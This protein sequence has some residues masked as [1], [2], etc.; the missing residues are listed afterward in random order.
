MER[1]IA[2]VDGS[3]ESRR[4][5]GT[6]AKLA[7]ALGS[8]LTLTLVI[9]T[10]EVMGEL[11]AYEEFERAHE[12]HAQTVLS[13]LKQEVDLPP[14]RLE[15]QLLKGSPAEAVAQAAEA[16][17]VGLIVVGNRGRGAVTR[18]LLGSVSDRLVHISPKP[19]LVIR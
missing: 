12:A 4:A 9:P 11:G 2:A 7:R 16:S 1:I 14:E 8:R 19:V 5:L 18:M 6:A 17:D 3:E 10:Y 13:D 15:T